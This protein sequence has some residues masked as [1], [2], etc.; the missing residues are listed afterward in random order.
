MSGNVNNLMTGKTNRNLIISHNTI[1]N[2]GGFGI[3]LAAFDAA[4]N[5]KAPFFTLFSVIFDIF[6]KNISRF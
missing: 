1:V 4:Y 6:S 3:R 2:S 5:R